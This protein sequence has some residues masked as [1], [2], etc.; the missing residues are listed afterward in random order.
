MGFDD[1]GGGGGGGGGGLEIVD[2]AAFT[3]GV[4]RGT[5]YDLPNATTDE[6]YFPSV[7]VTNYEETG[8][9]GNVYEGD[10]SKVGSRNICYSLEI[11]PDP[12]E[13]FIATG[14][15]TG[16]VEGI[17]AIYKPTQP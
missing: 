2:S 15:D 10:P 7:T 12:M 14:T 17:Y 13:L 8:N 16:T 5:R 4:N 6:L 1:P 3:Q 11:G 9:I